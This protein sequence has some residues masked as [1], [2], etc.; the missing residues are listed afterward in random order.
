MILRSPQHQAIIVQLSSTT[1]SLKKTAAINKK[2]CNLCL[3]IASVWSLFGIVAFV[4]TPVFAQSAIAP[5]NT[6]G[7]ENS[8]VVTNFNGLPVE[9]I[10]GGATRGVNLFHSFREFNVSEG[11]GAYFLSPGADI[12]NILARVTG[13]N[14]SEILGRL[15]TSQIINGNIAGSNANLFLINPNSIIFG[16]NAS[17]DVQGSF[18]GTTANG[19][20]FGNQGN[21][22]A[23]NPQAATL[24]T[25][26]PSALLFNQINQSGIINRSRQ[27]ATLGSLY[28]I[29]G[30]ITFDSG[31]ATSV[32]NRLELGAVAGT[33]T[34]ELIGSGN[35]MQ[36][37]F[38]EGIPKADIVLQNNAFAVTTGG[39]AISVNT[40][41]LS[42]FGNSLITATLAAGEGTPGI[43][44]GDVVVNATDDVTLDSLSGIS[45]LG[46]EN[47]LGDTG[48]IAINARSL[49]LTNGGNIGTQ[50]LERGNSGNL[51]VN[52]S[53]SVTLSGITTFINPQTG[54]T[55]TTVSRLSTSTFGTGKSGEL[56]IN[57]Q[58]LSVNDGGD[59]TTRT[60]LGS[61]ENLTINAKDLVEVVGRSPNASSNISTS[62]FG[63]GDAG[64][65][66]INAGRLSIRD[67]GIVTTL[68]SSTGKAGN[69]T[70]D[71]KDSVEV[72]GRSPSSP[73]SL[74]TIFTSTFGSGDAGSINIS[75]G[76]L[77][78]R[79]G[80]RVNTSTL[81]KGKA[82][83]LII[84]ADRSVE[85]IGTSADGRFF[86]G[87]LSSA[88]SG[89]TGDAGD[90]TIT[91]Q[92]FLVQ[93]GAQVNT[94]TSGVGKGGNLTINTS[95]KV[96]II[97]TSAD[98]RFFSG[99]GTSTNQGST[100]DAG[101]LTITTQDLLVRDGA[102]V[103]TGTSSAGKGGNLTVN[104]SSSVEV[105]GVS[106]N[107]FLNSSLSTSANQGLTG[108]AGDLT[109]NAQ[110][111]LVRDGGQVGAATSGQGKGGN[112]TVNATDK[113][114][115]IGTSLNGNT[116][117]VFSTSALAGST[118]NAG[119]LTINAQDL[120]VRNGAQITAATSGRG[121]AGNLNVNASKKVELIGTSADGR[122]IS[123]LGASVQQGST[124]DAGSLTIT[125]QDLLV[126]DGA[127][128]FTGTLGA[129]RAGNLTVNASNKV[130]LI[131]TSV[132][133]SPGG[134]I[135]S[136]EQG[137]TGDAGDLKITTQNLLV[138]DGAQVLASTFSS[139]RGGNLTVNASQNVQLI[140]QSVNSS[141]LSG[142]FASS[143][144]GA[145]GD[146]GN[147]AVNT[148]NLLAQD[149]AQ[150]IAS[151]F[152]SGKGGSLTVNAS[153]SVQLIGKSANNEFFSGLF[154]SAES[155]STGDAGDLKVNTQNLL[156]SNGA[157]IFVNSEGT[158]N[159]GIMT[160]N[161]DHIRLNNNA[162]INA[163]TR[164]PNK[165]PNREQ[166]TINLNTQNL[167]LRRNSKIT[168]NATGENVIGGNINID[169][170]LLIA[171]ENS[172]ISAN[173]DN[174][175]GGQVQI[176]A[177]GVFVGTQPSD[178][179]K[180]ITAT[181]GVG[182][183]GNV[184][185]NSPDN[186]TIQNS[187]SELPTNAIDTNAL[188]AN[189]CIARGNKK[190]ESSF[191][192]T[193]GGALPNRP[194][195]VSMSNYS[196]DRVRGV[197]N[198]NTSRPWKKG[199]RIIE[200]T[201]VYRLSDGR[202]VMSRPCE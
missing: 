100:G 102:T 10:T 181:S 85:L 169:T 14:R 130:E 122:I 142:L 52:A 115:L 159:A 185:V 11:R 197:N 165:D 16:Q 64:S 49:T 95:N 96:Q 83:N 18:V 91:S 24:L 29:G 54:E 41:N 71:A 60:E 113:V 108:N 3:K 37:A 21:F 47:S 88:E 67:G 161:T 34:I 72:V 77:S 93:N 70:I 55:I 138:R 168:T 193:G 179:S 134:L 116:L 19:V 62:T 53:D 13:S 140:G 75:A 61:G 26:N 65:L 173:S 170:D 192:I 92:D 89:S 152:N 86:T 69:L 189:S 196:T 199:D 163:N 17:L 128:V 84:N 167:T 23:T 111:L 123:G 101:D 155:N 132:N 166:A 59:I 81:G 7:A 126:Q 158:G 127:R 104:A 202:L 177:Q 38:P 112:L 66:N 180:Y 5:D 182:L 118:G 98:G 39:G 164:S 200:P 20:Q 31:V 9:V 94:G 105:I 156:V 117:S 151:T 63:S 107:G 149:G 136:A 133:G 143:E 8:N 187:L 45:S 99:L 48:N 27:I 129:G 74:S 97:G 103:I 145:T 188:I 195:D 119:D 147:I 154:A 57:T 141:F 36:L 194:G 6:L 73:N 137:S 43:S 184:N 175:R 125:T 87:L 90:L 171:L 12:Q 32:G 121:K 148:Q 144:K 15:G 198:E 51:L 68:T 139:G 40:G 82:G 46:L 33:G 174:S 109:I 172:R 35:Q 22:S 120:F 201:G 160:I 76:S 80:A 183:S 56:T 162:S 114:E 157:G 153:E 146:A 50:S 190:Q 25:V 110:N 135:A 124:G 28:L 79:D 58:R 186:S 1:Q 178:V 30:N 4:Q 106:A 176:N 78:I 131:G 42:L 2:F 150:V 191:I 44:A